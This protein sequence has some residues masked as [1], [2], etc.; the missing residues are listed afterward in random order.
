MSSFELM[1]WSVYLEE[2]GEGGS[3]FC[4]YDVKVLHG[5]IICRSDGLLYPFPDAGAE[6]G[7]HRV[8]PLCVVCFEFRPEKCVVT[9]LVSSML[10]AH[11]CSLE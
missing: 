1:G 9:E 8:Y 11:M 7:L 2:R 4:S 5:W 10:N 3:E 6:V